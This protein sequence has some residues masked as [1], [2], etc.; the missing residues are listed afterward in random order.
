[1]RSVPRWRSDA[2]SA[3]STR[4]ESATR[5]SRA[6]R[7]GA[8]CSIAIDRPA[9]QQSLSPLMS[10]IAAT[11]EPWTRSESKRRP[12]RTDRARWPEATSR[13]TDAPSFCRAAV[14]EH[15]VQRLGER[16]HNRSRLARARQVREIGTDQSALALHHV[17]V[18]ALA[19]AS[20]DLFAE[21]GVAF[22]RRIDRRA[23]K[24]ADVRRDFRD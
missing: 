1:M 18:R 8:G 20:E 11:P 14:A 13:S 15:F 17:A 7:H 6:I 5:P 24:R 4:T 23:A 2:V 21:R 16:V 10:M 3:R 22:C 9:R 12:T 19:F